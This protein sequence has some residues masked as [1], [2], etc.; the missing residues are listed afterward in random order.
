MVQHRASY[1]GSSPHEDSC[2]KRWEK[3]SNFK[4]SMAVAAGHK[5]AVHLVRDEICLSWQVKKKGLMDNVHCW[6]RTSLLSVW[7]TP[8]SR[9]WYF[10]FQGLDFVLLLW[11]GYCAVIQPTALPFRK[12]NT[13]SCCC[14][15]KIQKINT[16]NYIL[17]NITW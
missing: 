13:H 9:T 16:I 7:K 5:M 8:F 10:L 1:T 6:I 15:L 17:N 14:I 2:T 12:K 4:C 11:L 3:Q